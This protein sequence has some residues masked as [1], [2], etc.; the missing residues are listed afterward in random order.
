MSRSA[1][2]QCDKCGREAYGDAASRVCDRCAGGT[3]GPAASVKVAR[4][5]F[6]ITEPARACCTSYGVHSSPV[7]AEWLLVRTD[8][9]IWEGMALC[10][11]CVLE[12][13][14]GSF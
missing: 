10:R 5:G 6:H 9:G 11:E 4:P 14:L 8:G 7:E 2:I 12:Y 3:G 1:F 13:K